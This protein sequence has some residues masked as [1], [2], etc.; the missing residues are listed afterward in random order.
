V[1][2]IVAQINGKVRSK[3]EMPT[4]VSQAEVEAMAMQDP[5][6]QKF[7]AGL[8]VVKQ[9]YVPNKLLNIVARPQ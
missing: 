9:I 6:I 5:Q 3:F 1:V 8:S 7:L 4:G 2:T